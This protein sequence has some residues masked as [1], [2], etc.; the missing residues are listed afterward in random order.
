MKLQN[1]LIMY[2]LVRKKVAQYMVKLEH[3]EKVY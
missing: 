2:Y 3:L 1:Y